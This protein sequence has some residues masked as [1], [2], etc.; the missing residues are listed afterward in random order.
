[1]TTNVQMGQRVD[2][3]NVGSLPSQQ[4]PINASGQV[5]RYPGVSNAVVPMTSGQN[6]QPVITDGRGNIYPQSNPQV[7]NN[8]FINQQALNNSNFSGA[9]SILTGQA[10]PPARLGTTFNPNGLLNNSNSVTL[11]KLAS[12]PGATTNPLLRYVPQAGALQK[13]I[14]SPAEVSDAMFEAAQNGTIGSIISSLNGIV[15]VLLKDSTSIPI[16]NQLGSFSGGTIGP[17]ETYNPLTSLMSK[18]NAGKENDPLKETLGHILVFLKTLPLEASSPTSSINPQTGAVGALNKPEFIATAMRRADLILGLDGL[19][20]NI[21]TYLDARG[22]NTGKAGDESIKSIQ[23]A[24]SGAA[25]GGG[26]AE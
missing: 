5:V 7:L 3:N 9:S 26:N 16:I 14:T 22:K 2:V 20:K 23:D 6:G 10:A 8:P 12:I 21:K 11:Q 13:L 17:G 4:Q 19:S 24:V 15:N 1:M 18:N 25:G